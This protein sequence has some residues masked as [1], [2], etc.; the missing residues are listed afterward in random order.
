M[1]RN[2][3]V[4]RHVPLD[5]STTMPCTKATD[6]IQGIN[7]EFSTGSQAQY[8]PHPSVSYAQY[9][10]RKIPKPRVTTVKTVQGIVCL[11]QSLYLLVAR[12][13][14]A[15]ANGMQAAAYPTKTMGG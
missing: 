11:T 5:F 14:M 12:A 15:K 3:F 8:P 13:A 6:T 7:E 4:R 10:P 1:A 2:M 9:P